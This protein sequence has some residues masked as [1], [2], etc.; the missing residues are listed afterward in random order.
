MTYGVR[1]YFDWQG[2]EVFDEIG[3]FDAYFA[4]LVCVDF[5]DAPY[6]FGITPVRVTRAIVFP[7]TAV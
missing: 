4:H 1:V 6:T 2:S 5:A 7:W 3:P